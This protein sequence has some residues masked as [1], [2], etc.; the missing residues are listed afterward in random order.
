MWKEK[1][2]TTPRPNVEVLEKV[3][4][5]HL[6]KLAPLVVRSEIRLAQPSA[7]QC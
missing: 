5:K 4:S 1:T 6:A 3:D 2:F 7:T